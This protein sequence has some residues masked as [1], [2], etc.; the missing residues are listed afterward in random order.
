MEKEGRSSSR[1]SFSALKDGRVGGGF[2]HFISVPTSLVLTSLVL[3]TGVR[4]LALLLPSLSALLPLAFEDADPLLRVGQR[5]FEFLLVPSQVC[6]GF[7]E[8]HQTAF[9]VFGVAFRLFQLP[10]QCPHVVPSASASEARPASSVPDILLGDLKLPLHLI[11]PRVRLPEL[12]PQRVSFLLQ[13]ED[14]LR[15]PSATTAVLSLDVRP[16]EPAG[17]VV[18]LHYRLAVSHL[19]NNTVLPRLLFSVPHATGVPDTELTGRLP[20]SALIRRCPL[21]SLLELFLQF[22][23]LRRFSTPAPAPA[24]VEALDSPP[25]EP[26]ARPVRFHDGLV[27]TKL[28]HR[29]VA[30]ALPLRVPHPH[31]VPNREPLLSTGACF[32]LQ[33]DNP[34]A[35]LDKLL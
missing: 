11:R 17:L 12:L 26:P 24:S 6:I 27:P 20:S 10:L 29:P 8:G 31:P 5:L 19:T 22:R 2:L 33:L 30:P 9:V 3:T 21:F 25:G 4:T 7:G 32:R 18:E 13:L 1:V 34:L 14:L 28:D 15:A 35:Q 16:C 23:D